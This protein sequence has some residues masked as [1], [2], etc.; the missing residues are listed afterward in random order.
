MEV[1]RFLCWEAVEILVLMLLALAAAKAIRQ[2]TSSLAQGGNLH[3]CSPPTRAKTARY[4]PGK[5]VGLALNAVLLAL[6]GLGARGIGNRLAAEFYFM[7]SERNLAQ[8]EPSRAYTNALRAVR[9]EPHAIE[10]WQMLSATKFAL[11]QYS[12]VVGDRATF[13]SL[14][15]GHL[16]EKD[17]M[18]FAFAHFFLGQYEPAIE[19]AAQVLKENRTYPA[20]YLLLGTAYSAQRRYVEAERFFQQVLQIYPTQ[21]AAVEGLSHAYFL[22]GDAARA[23]AV[24]RETTRFPFNPEARKRFDELS[25]LYKAGQ[26]ATGGLATN[27]PGG[28]ACGVFSLRD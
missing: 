8:S 14:E 7:A 23:L 6:A 20:P 18:R 10:Y 22:G 16:D 21:E 15:R 12:S 25:E 11:Q 28:N 24:L 3:A 13:E 27:G 19:L 2:W 26:G 5:L 4:G 1:I 9:L 17:A